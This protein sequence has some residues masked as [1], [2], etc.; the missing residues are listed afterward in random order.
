MRTRRADAIS[1]PWRRDGENAPAPNLPPPHIATCYRL[2][3]LDLHRPDSGDEEFQLADRIRLEMAGGFALEPIREGFP[4][5]TNRLK[6]AHRPLREKVAELRVCEKE[7]ANLAREESGLGDLR[8]EK[9]AADNAARKLTQLDAALACHR[10]DQQIKE[11]A[12][13]LAAVPE[14]TQ[15]ARKDDTQELEKLD[16]R[17]G[18]YARAI[19]TL[20]DGISKRKKEIAAS[21]VAGDVGQLDLLIAAALK[22]SEVA[23]A[24]EQS[25]ERAA[26]G[27]DEARQNVSPVLLET[28]TDPGTA[29]AARQLVA[30][31]GQQAQVEARIEAQEAALRA[32]EEPADSPGESPD[33]VDPPWGELERPQTTGLIFGVVG[34]GVGAAL[35]FLTQYTAAVGAACAGLVL[36]GRY[37]HDRRQNQGARRRVEQFGQAIDKPL[38]ANWTA[39]EAHALITEALQ[40]EGS[41]RG[42]Q[43]ARSEARALFQQRLQDAER[44]GRE[45]QARQQELLQKHGQDSARDS[46]DVAHEWDHLRRWREAS[47]AHAEAR[48]A[49]GHDTAAAA[50]ALRT[51]HEFLISLGE[52]GGESLA[53][54]QAGQK[55]IQDRQIKTGRLEEAL[56]HDQKTLQSES[57][58]LAEARDERQSLL[59]R[60]GLSDQEQG[61]DEVA[62]MVAERVA[63]LPDWQKSKDEHRVATEERAR[64]ADPLNDDAAR[65]LL[66]KSDEEL[67]KLRLEEAIR[68]EAP[69]DLSEKIGALEQRIASA[70]AGSTFE[71]AHADVEKATDELS[72]RLEAQR[73]GLAAQLLLDDVANE[74][75]RDTMPPVLRE[76]NRLLK[77]FTEGRYELR[78]LGS[79]KKPR[80]AALDASGQALDL[81]QLS[82]GTRAQLLLAA[83]L[84]FLSQAEAGIRLP[85]FLDEALT[86]SDPVRFGAVATALGRLSSASERQV[87]YLTSNPGDVGAWRQALSA[88]GLTA[89]HVIDL[90]DIRKISAAASAAQLAEPVIAPVPPT[91]GHDPE[92]YGQLLQVP[93]LNPRLEAAELHLLHLCRDDLDLIRRLVVAGMSSLGQWQRMG[94]DLM[95][96]GVFAADEGALISRRGEVYGHFVELWRVGRGRPLTRE[97]LRGSKAFTDK[98][99]GPAIAL[100]EEVAG[101]AAT[102]LDSVFHKKGIP[103]LRTGSKETLR[104]HLEGQRYLD[105]RPVLEPE[106]IVAL[107]LPLINAGLNSDEIRALVLG[108]FAH[109]QQST[110]VSPPRP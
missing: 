93:A 14:G 72:R 106:E 34:L 11:W 57:T 18:K 52:S 29:E 15:H 22:A 56:A 81:H 35:A 90:G 40:T 19:A 41:T 9:E 39:A 17:V 65:A 86:A 82:D 51:A 27:L 91:A 58:H 28:G 84:A 100:M 85:L 88:S 76:M 53:E 68:A 83:R 109:A 87:F 64:R 43:A 7:H 96:A 66:E 45:A 63:A 77:L 13:K 6:L 26:A 49:C 44:T 23:F 80:L 10:L 98:F 70:R 92:S 103:N 36:C 59:A 101:D 3:L 24:S 25:R 62:A 74:H 42:A 5:E 50:N 105:K 48:G 94:A 61:P 20:E 33:R 69:A 54:A 37:V 110:L 8:A 79:E 107:T 71:S 1:E 30:Q 78:I 73:L 46:A 38:A 108:F 4:D 89:P 12:T 75:D 104:E 102:F 60:L 55:R 2:G 31:N 16:N 99:M 32:L 95:V 21:A 47:V 67:T 97:A